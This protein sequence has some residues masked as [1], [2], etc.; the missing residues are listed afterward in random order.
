M[1]GLTSRLASPLLRGLE[2]RASFFSPSFLRS[3]YGLLPSLIIGTLLGD[4]LSFIF[5]NLTILGI[6]IVVI[7][8]IVFPIQFT[9][10]HC[11][12]CH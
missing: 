8:I 5:G 9:W 4:L 1:P 12:V 3:L 11:H 6:I 2:Y 10:V 7:V